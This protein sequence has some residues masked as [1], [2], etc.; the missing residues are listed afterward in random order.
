MT[1]SLQLYLLEVCRLM[2][3]SRS[4]PHEG[5][6]SPVAVFKRSR[7]QFARHGKRIGRGDIHNH[8]AQRLHSFRRI[9]I[10]HLFLRFNRQQIVV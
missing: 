6:G 9:T 2:A 3:Q 1:V 10:I 5:G 4:L 7:L 8:I